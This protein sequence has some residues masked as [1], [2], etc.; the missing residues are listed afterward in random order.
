MANAV[1]F[2]AL[3]TAGVIH[4]FQSGNGGKRAAALRATQSVRLCCHV[5]HGHGHTDR[6]LALCARLTPLCAHA[7][8]GN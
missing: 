3:V 6:T 5:H 1:L 7:A 4:T 8:S 2:T